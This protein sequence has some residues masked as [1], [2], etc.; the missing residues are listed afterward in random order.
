VEYFSTSVVGKTGINGD[1]YYISNQKDVFAIS[2]GASGSLDKVGA[3]KC[4][5]DPLGKLEYD[6]N[7]MEALHYITQCINVANESLIEKSQNEGKLSFGTISLCVLKDNI[8]YTGSVG[9]TPVFLIKENLMIRLVKPKKRYS[10]AVEH[11]VISEEDAEKAVQSLPGPL[12]SVFDSFLPMIIPQIALSSIE[13]NR[14]DILFLC[15]D[16]VTDW[17][18]PEEIVGILRNIDK[19]DTGCIEILNKVEER[20]PQNCLDDR[21]IVAVKF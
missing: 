16:G 9:D 12:Q 14:N 13:I 2:D 15:C 19:L 21:T 8:L 10:N 11:G 7:T 1:K 17:I 3:S 4:C 5:I 18:K 6:K 20:C